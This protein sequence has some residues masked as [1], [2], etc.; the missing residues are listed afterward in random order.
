MF[1][2]DE[3]QTLIQ[4]LDKPFGT[5]VALM[6]FAG[7]RSEEVMGLRWGDIDQKEQ[8]ITVRRVVTRVAKGEYAP[9]ER[10]KN[11]KVRYIPYGDELAAHLKQAPKTSLYV[12]P[13]VRG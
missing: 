1:S 8:V 3:I 9:V 10:T 5:A 6:L 2:L 7:L 13:A 12:V 4:N 11:A